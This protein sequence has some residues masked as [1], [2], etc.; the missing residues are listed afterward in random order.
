MLK[1]A[2]LLAKIGADTAENAQH[3][4]EILIKI[5]RSFLT[6]SSIASSTGPAA[7]SAPDPQAVRSDLPRRRRVGLR[8]RTQAK[9]STERF[10]IMDVQ[11]PPKTLRGSFSAVSKPIFTSKYSLASS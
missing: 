10:H 5:G 9:E 8:R 3:V 11:E 6:P 2:Y 7:R 4:A 1:N